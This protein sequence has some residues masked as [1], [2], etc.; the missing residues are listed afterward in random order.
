MGPWSADLPDVSPPEKQPACQRGRLFKHTLRTRVLRTHARTHTGL[1]AKALLSKLWL[2]MEGMGIVYCVHVTAG[3]LYA[4]ATEGF[5]CDV[6]ISHVLS[7]L[8]HTKK[9]GF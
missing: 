4:A 8:T 6:I 7:Y 2:D 1:G 3:R 9:P 5:K